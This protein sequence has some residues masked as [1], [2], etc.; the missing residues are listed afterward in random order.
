MRSLMVL[1]FTALFIS[2][3]P[4]AAEQHGRKK[5]AAAKKQE[6]KDTGASCKA[7][8][9]GAC[10]SCAITCRPGESAT[11]GPGMLSGDLCARPPSCTCK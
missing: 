11:C 9:V 5:T 3:S 10:A 4:A 7:P 1:V 2:T 6:K 8:A